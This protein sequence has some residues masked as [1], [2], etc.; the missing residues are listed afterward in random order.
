MNPAV[1][2]IG[3][4]LATL[5]V[6]WFGLSASRALQRSHWRLSERRRVARLWHEHAE[7][8]AEETAAGSDPEHILWE[9]RRDADALTAKAERTATEMLAEAQ[10]SA[11]S[12]VS[13]AEQRAR[14]IV[15]AAE[16][17]RA[18]AE[19]EASTERRLITEKR[20][21]LSTLLAS[22]LEQVR[23]A[24]E[25]GNWNVFDLHHARESRSSKASAAE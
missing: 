1:V 16:A 2:G 19:Q 24:A 18:R 8:R 20:E 21:E 3:A 17:M 15:A 11:G 9:A 10:R 13:Q 4:A 5:V 23:L 22:F 6:G 25:T 12:I 7:A 14:E